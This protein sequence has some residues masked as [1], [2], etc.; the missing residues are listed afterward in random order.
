MGVCDGVYVGVCVIVSTHENIESK[1][2]DW[3]K[4]DVTVGVCWIQLTFKR[5]ESKSGQTL[6]LPDGPN[7]TG[8]PLTYSERYHWVAPVL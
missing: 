8:N 1:L 4:S 2:K 3:Q 6:L 5:D 7:T